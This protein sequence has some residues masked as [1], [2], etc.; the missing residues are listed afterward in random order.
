MNRCFGNVDNVSGPRL[1]SFVRRGVVVAATV[2]LM[3]CGMP[4]R[5]AGDA[6]AAPGELQ[7]ELA[8]LNHSWNTSLERLAAKCDELKREALA[9]ETR[10]WKHNR[11][12]GATRLFLSPRALPP[13]PPKDSVEE[14]LRKHIGTLRQQRSDALFSLAQKHAEQSPTLAYQLCCEALALN[15][16]SAELRTALGYERDER[17]GRDGDLWRRGSFYGRPPEINAAGLRVTAS[18]ARPNNTL[19][20]LSHW[21]IR[22]AHFEILSE[23]GRGEAERL[24]EEL[25]M[26]YD[27]WAQLFVPFWIDPATLARNLQSGKPATPPSGRHRVVLYKDRT[28]YLTALRRKEPRIDV[29]V[30]YYRPDDKVSYFYGADS[31]P[32][33][34]WRH[35]VA[36][37]L[38]AEV[39]RMA[40]GAGLRDNFWALEGIAMYMESV[41]MDGQGRCYVGGPGVDRLQFAR[42]RMSPDAESLPR[43]VAQGR[44]ELQSDPA[45]SELYSDAAALACFL[46]DGRGQALR[47]NGIQFLSLVYQGRNAS[48]LQ[49]TRHPD[50]NTLIRE[51]HQFLGA[52][53][54]AD[55]DALGAPKNLCLRHTNVSSHALAEIDGSRLEWLDCAGRPY[56][57]AALQSLLRS[58]PHLR[59]LTLDSTSVTDTAVYSSNWNLGSGCPELKELDLSNTAITDAAIKHLGANLETLW[60]TNTQVTAASLPN[61]LRMK[62]LKMLDVG[63]LHFTQEQLESL[64]EGLPLLDDVK[65]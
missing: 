3:L 56:T 55:I 20:L 60:L 7:R 61:L 63:G 50:F 5:A 37:Q 12:A 1:R 9:K 59:Q 8:Q 25:E 24:G 26:V 51:H 6:K 65:R 58:A 2:G 40:P 48:L 42:L 27:A 14:S 52:F 31:P 18:R 38:F 19:S 43:L 57:S 30:G 33:D 28:R 39:R 13:Q 35:E 53:E 47:E 17:G 22:T 11:H 15:P 46:M 32:R 44:V 36:H 54:N 62:R 29:S 49:H 41:R 23:L 21:R 4:V 45:V 16:A 34:T 64:I 10:A